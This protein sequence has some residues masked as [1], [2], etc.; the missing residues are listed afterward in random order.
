MT[1]TSPGTPLWHMFPEFICPTIRRIDKLIDRFI[2]DAERMAF[3]PHSPGNRFAATIHGLSGRQAI[4]VAHSR[5]IEQTSR[6][7]CGIL[8]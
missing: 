6:P 3:Q 1:L 8:S 4:G 5:A 7:G 2:A